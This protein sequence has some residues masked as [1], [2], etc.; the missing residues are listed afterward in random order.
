MELYHYSDKNN[1]DYML[2][3]I[4]KLGYKGILYN[5]GSLCIVN[6]FCDINVEIDI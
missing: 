1:I 6:L 5:I 2:K 3:I 4:K